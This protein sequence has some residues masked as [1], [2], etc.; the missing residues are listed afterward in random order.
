VFYE[1]LTWFRV[2]WLCV[3]VARPLWR[4][5]HPPVPVSVSS[6][7]RQT[8][9]PLKPRTPNDGPGCGR[10]PPTPLWGDP[11]Q[12]GG[13]PWRERKSPRGRRKAIGTAGDAC[14]NPDCDYHGNTDSTFHALVGE[15]KRSADHLQWL[16][17]QACGRRF[18]SRLGTALYRLRT[19]AAKVAQVLLAVN[20]GLTL[21][22]AQPPGAFGSYHFCRPHFRGGSSSRCRKHGES[23]RHAGM[24]RAPQR[25][26]HCT[27]GASVAAGLTDP[28]GS[29]EELL[30]FPVGQ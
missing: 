20:L 23:R 22:D 30:A 16:C 14:P 29:G 4:A 28:L 25:H 19:P 24:G 11:R 2:L 15:G 18:S 6:P 9:H 27:A 8:P 26:L 5:A 10:P 7:T 13:L 3:R 12:A 17:C 1:H 21:A